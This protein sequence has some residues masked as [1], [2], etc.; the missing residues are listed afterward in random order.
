V[1]ELECGV[2]GSSSEEALRVGGGRPLVACGRLRVTELGMNG[3]RCARH[4]R[5]QGGGT[6]DPRI[7]RTSPG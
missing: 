7:Q 5:R 6:Q 1:S 3:C 2:V 4:Q